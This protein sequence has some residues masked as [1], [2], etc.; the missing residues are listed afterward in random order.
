MQKDR[1]IHARRGEHRAVPGSVPAVLECELCR[2]LRS[3]T[4]LSGGA[5]FL[6]LPLRGRDP[7]PDGTGLQRLKGDGETDNHLESLFR[8]TQSLHNEQE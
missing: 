5:G 6:R 2:E 8:Q 4:W 1:K 7:C 3:Q